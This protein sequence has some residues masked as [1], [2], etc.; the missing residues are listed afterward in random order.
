MLRFM[1]SRRTKLA[2]S[3]HR[4]AATSLRIVTERETNRF[5]R[6]NSRI[7]FKFDAFGRQK[8]IH[9]SMKFQDFLQ[10]CALERP[11]AQPNP[12]FN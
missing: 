2:S 1:K 9:E 11:K 7:F 6:L 8:P 5:K 10:I 4:E 3:K 12:K